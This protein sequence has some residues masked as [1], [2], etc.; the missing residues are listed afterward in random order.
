[1]KYPFVKQEGLKDCG[2]A[3]LLM[4]IRYYDGNISL[5]KLRDM[6]KTDKNGVTAYHLKSA[7]EKIGLKC[8]AYKIESLYQN[9]K[10]PCIAH[11]TNESFNHYVV[12]YEID[13]DKQELIIADPASRIK[14]MSFNDFNKIFNNVVLVFQKI[15]LIQNEKNISF[16]QFLF[17]LF[18]QN[19]TSFLKIVIL[20]FFVT[21]LSIITS[22][23]I[24]NLIN[25]IDNLNTCLLLFIVFLIIYILKNTMDYIRNNILIKLKKK[26][27]YCLSNDIFSN[28]ILLPYKYFKNRTTGEVLTRISDLEIVI[29]VIIK[30]IVTVILDSLLTIISSIFLF[31]I[32]NKLFLISIIVLLLYIFIVYKFSS[33]IE[34]SLKKIKKNKTML[35]SYIVENLTGFETIKGLGIEN[36]IINKY[37]KINNK[38]NSY[39]YDYQNIYNKEY[40][41]KNMINDI[42]L[43]IIIFIGILLIIHNDMTLANLITYTLLFNYFLTP[44]T[45][46]IDLNKD[47]KDAKVSYNRINDL[48]FNKKDNN[49][50]YNIPFTNIKIKNL[51]YSY[52]DIKNNINNINLNIKENDKII[53]TGSS[54]SGKSTILKIL[55]KY[56]QIEDNKVFIND[57]DI[58]KI[59]IEEINQNIKYIS[60]NE[61]LFTDTLNN[62]LDLNRNID[63]N[64]INEVMKLVHINKPL[65]LFIEED[66]FNL[67]GGERQR[68]ILA[69]SLLSDFNILIL[70][71]SLNQLDIKL[72]R[73]ILDNILKKYNDKIIIYVTHRNENIDLFNKIIN[74]EKGKIKSISNRKE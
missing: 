13:N 41:Y 59:S 33:Y 73:K 12:I 64:K 22:F 6:T 9:I 18:K 54:G 69:R 47:I 16:N 68:I 4:I 48:L 36:N 10:L 27:E 67:S 14:K 21:L 63:S 58:N 44:I 40:Y 20:S 50:E 30:L 45:N 43:L 74:L 71:E 70:D 56:Y 52:D 15:N 55:K 31:K 46:I 61:I 60:Q 66:G 49:N 7:S 25:N 26:I 34:N 11:I 39:N 53:I 24:G 32:S 23:Y 65:N 3:C 8:D 57:I 28:V 1:M 17:M 29:D 5:E 2:V 62:N 35:N 19:K 37:K 51:S 38:Y 72:E 42:G